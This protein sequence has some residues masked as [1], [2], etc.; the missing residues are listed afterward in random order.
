MLKT[1]CMIGWHSNRLFW[2]CSNTQNKHRAAAMSSKI[3]TLDAMRFP[4]RTALEVSSPKGADF[5]RWVEPRDLSGRLDAAEWER[6]RERLLWW[7]LSNMYLF[8]LLIRP[9]FPS[10][11]P[12]IFVGIT[13][14]LQIHS[15]RTPKP[16][17]YTPEP[18]WGLQLFSRWALG[19]ALARIPSWMWCPCILHCRPGRRPML[20]VQPT[21]SINQCM[22]TTP[23]INNDWSTP[24]TV[25]LENIGLVQKLSQAFVGSSP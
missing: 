20:D 7:N 22:G 8:S 5:D 13:N 12:N 2:G 15:Q 23:H 25:S 19:K 18:W 9:E 6:L 14:N 11:K 16:S 21:F 10:F 17:C 3:A 24:A 4:I 1:F